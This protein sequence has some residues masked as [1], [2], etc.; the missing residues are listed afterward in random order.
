MKQHLPEGYS[1]V[2]LGFTG[3]S[4][5]LGAACT[6]GVDN[7]ALDKTPTQVAQAVDTAWRASIQAVTIS[8]L[9]LAT[10]HVKNGPNLDGPFA[11]FASGAP[12]SDALDP[13]SSAVCY[14]VK[15]NTAL[16]GKLGHG[17]MFH[18][19]LPEAQTGDGG[20]ILAGFVT[21]LQ[22]A[23]N[24][25][26]TNLSTASIPMV[27]IHNAG[28]YVNAEGATVTV[29]PRVPTPVLSLAI[30]PKVATQRRRQ[31]R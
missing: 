7:Q 10:V 16:G 13:T 21:D 14:L 12:G 4:Q 18:P 29:A 27:L 9:T 15:K 8:K 25:F 30:D 31:R 23:W 17:R 24:T 22:T 3:V 5:P 26:F 20:S 19:G 11:D 2:L 1:H 28:S 6:F